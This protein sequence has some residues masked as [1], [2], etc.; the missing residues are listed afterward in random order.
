[1]SHDEDE[2]V[3]RLIA[4]LA[5]TRSVLREY[6]VDGWARKLTTHLRA[7]QN[8]D[9]NGLLALR[10]AF[11]TMGALNDVCICPENGHRIAKEDVGSVNNQLQGLT[12]DLR[13]LSR[14]VTKPMLRRIRA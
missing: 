6:G 11:G 14:R 5:K 8:R 13:S 9:V 2:L 7:I 10:N 3:R 1:M 12:A 4:T